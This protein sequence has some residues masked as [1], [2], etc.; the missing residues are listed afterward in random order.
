MHTR[1]LQTSDIPALMEMAQKS[2][3]PYPDFSSARAEA[4]IVVVDD[5]DQ[6]LMACFAERLVQLYLICGE[7]KRPLANVHAVRLLHEAMA[8]ILKKQGYASVEAFL[9]PTLAERFGRRL[10]KTFGWT[11]NWPSWNRSI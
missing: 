7:M 10:V 2:G 4:F 8:P 11:R 9:P 5:D 1:P 3:Y 6:P